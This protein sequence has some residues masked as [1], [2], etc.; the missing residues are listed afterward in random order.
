MPTNRERFAMSTD[1]TFRMTIVDVF[2][3]SGLGTV[4]AG[5]VELGT[6]KVGDQVWL[7]GDEGAVKTGVAFIQ[8]GTKGVKTAAV[9]DLVGVVLRGLRE[10]RVRVGNVLSAAES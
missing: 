8:A 4:A 2:A 1:P 9:G 3:I 5:R 7:H 10:D 6:I